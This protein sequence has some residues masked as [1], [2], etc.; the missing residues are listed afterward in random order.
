MSYTYSRNLVESDTHTDFIPSYARR[1][2]KVKK[3]RTW[4]VLAPIAGIALIGG[5]MALLMSSGTDDAQ[6]MA[7]PVPV[8]ATQAPAVTATAMAPAVVSSAKPAVVA[9]PTPGTR[10][11]ESQPRVDRPSVRAAA[12]RVQAPAEPTGPSPYT[13]APMATAPAPRIT[14]APVVQP[15]ATSPAPVISVSPLN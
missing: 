9:A 10:T 5:A 12:P 6:P 15:S 1:A 14:T 13:T 8:A 2:T 7:E 4:M 11:A 3:V